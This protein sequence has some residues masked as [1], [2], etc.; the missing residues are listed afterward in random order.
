MVGV[1]DPNTNPTTIKIGE[2]EI[3]QTISKQPMNLNKPNNQ[4]DMC[5]VL[6]KYVEIEKRFLNNKNNIVEK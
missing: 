6:T 3:K 5:E 2:T 4:A 1:E